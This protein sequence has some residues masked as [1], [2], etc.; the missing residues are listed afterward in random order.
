MNKHEAVAAVIQTIRR[1]LA[2]DELPLFGSDD[3]ES[4]SAGLR[5]LCARGQTC[6]AP[7]ITSAIGAEAIKSL[8]DVVQAALQAEHT[9]ALQQLRACDGPQ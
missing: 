3:F 5:F 8:L 4:L 1:R 2:G 7:E 9:I 6:E